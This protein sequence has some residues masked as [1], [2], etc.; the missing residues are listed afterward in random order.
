MGA[1]ALSLLADCSSVALLRYFSY[2]MLGDN[3]R[4][5]ARF[6]V[7]GPD[8]A[9]GGQILRVWA[10]FCVCGSQDACGLTLNKFA[11]PGCV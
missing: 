9:C 6:C 3:L 2:N 8:S 4:V 7:C 11:R 1:A 10:R 5:W